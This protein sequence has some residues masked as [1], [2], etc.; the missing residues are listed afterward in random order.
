VLALLL[1]TDARRPARLDPDG[2][3]VLLAD[4][5]RGRWDRARID[6]GL[7]LLDDAMKRGRTGPY[8]LQAA[9]AACHASASS[10]AATDWAQIA[11]LYA[12]LAH[13]DPTPVV[14]ANRAVAVAMAAGPEA[15]LAVL[16]SVQASWHLLHACRA[17][18]LRELGREA[19][20]RAAYLTALS[21]A[22]PPAERAF[23]HRQLSQGPE[24]AA[25]EAR[26]GAGCCCPGTG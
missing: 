26:T 18:L 24:A 23:L 14:H 2:D 9:I 6:E 1:L 12:A 5:D 22:P 21:L 25:G 11:L 15:G 7:G 19:E 3:L 13:W 8:Q 20:A 4:Q 16:D 10:S 17:S